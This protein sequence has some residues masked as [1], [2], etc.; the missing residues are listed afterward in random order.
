MYG[1][2]G[3]YGD[4]DHETF[5]IPVQEVAREASPFVYTF[6]DS[7][8]SHLRLALCPLLLLPYSPYCGLSSYNELHSLIY[9]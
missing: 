9:R 5:D 6:F 3:M 1:D 4:H 7:S 8:L 2:H